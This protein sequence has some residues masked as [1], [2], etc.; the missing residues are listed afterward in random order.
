MDKRLMDLWI[1]GQCEF[2]E[3]AGGKTRAVAGRQLC[4]Y[5]QITD[6]VCY[7]EFAYGPG[8]R[9]FGTVWT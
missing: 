3:E 1:Y 6:Y 2:R 8:I 9:R 4:A 5:A 7:A